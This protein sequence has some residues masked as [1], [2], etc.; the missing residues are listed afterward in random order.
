M[1]SPV[2][3]HP[4]AACLVMFA[5][6]GCASNAFATCTVP[7]SLTNGQVADASEVMAN[8]DAVAACADAAVKPTGTPTSGAVAVFSGSQ[9]ITSGNLTGDVTTAGTT[10][11]T[12][13]N[14]GV[15]PGTYTSANIAIDAKGRITAAANGTGGG[16]STDI[17]MA[18][19][20]A[21]AKEMVVNGGAITAGTTRSVKADKGAYVGMRMISNTNAG[22]SSRATGS[23]TYTVPAGALAFVVRGE[24]TDDQRNNTNYYG[25][26]LYN[27]TQGRVAAG[28]TMTDANRTTPSQ[29]PGTSSWSLNFSGAMTT[30]VGA[31]ST[32]GV[33]AYYPIAGSAGDVLQLEAWTS[34][35]GAYRVQD[36]AVYLVIVD[37]TT[38]DPIP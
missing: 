1:N 31:F 15:T 38:G 17:I 18:L 8:F 19:G 10:V 35:D 27:V 3:C 37:A 34:G 9:T 26:R 23:A 7:N 4:F 21:W 16:T 2:K 30:N 32:S 25:S 29:S 22:F 24:F 11:T 6:V 28:A 12:L 20:A 5:A 14:T 33:Q 36:M 13:S